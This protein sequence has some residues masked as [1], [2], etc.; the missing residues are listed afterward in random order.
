MAIYA[1]EM[2]IRQIE[3]S[4]RKVSVRRS[5]QLRHYRRKSA[6]MRDVGHDQVENWTGRET[7]ECGGVSPSFT[8]G[9]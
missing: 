5:S 8:T 2:A 4:V 7:V 9:A 3:Q 6:V 1:T